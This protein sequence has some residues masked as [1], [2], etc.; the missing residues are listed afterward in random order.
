MG[1]VVLGTTTLEDMDE[2]DGVVVVSNVFF[3]VVVGSINA[4]DDD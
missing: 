3:V 1:G 2:L 4:G